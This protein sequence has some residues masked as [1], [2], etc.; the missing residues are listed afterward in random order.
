MSDQFPSGQPPPGLLLVFES[1]SVHSDA[2]NLPP[3]VLRRVDRPLRPIEVSAVL[4]GVEEIYLVSLMR[5]T[6]PPDAWRGSDWLWET[7]GRSLQVRLKAVR[8]ESPLHVLLDLPWPVYA[9]AFSGFAFGLAHVFGAPLR[10]AAAF[11]RARADFWETRLAADKRK[12]EWL[13]WKR[14]EAEKRVPFKLREVQ[15]RAHLPASGEKEPD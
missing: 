14:A 7:H 10:A 15:I 13:E 8:L 5:D 1:P 3:R 12:Q 6:P 4:T 11:E 9:T 2:P